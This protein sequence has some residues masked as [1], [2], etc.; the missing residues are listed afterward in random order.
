LPA[1]TT[2]YSVSGT[3]VTKE[4]VKE[5]RE[6]LKAHTVEEKKGGA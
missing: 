1:G 3:K 4:N 5:H 2:T 6:K